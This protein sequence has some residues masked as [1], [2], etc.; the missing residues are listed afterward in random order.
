MGREIMKVILS[1]NVEI[2][3]NNYLDSLKNYGISAKRAQKQNRY[4]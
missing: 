1:K 4:V 3:M 2:G